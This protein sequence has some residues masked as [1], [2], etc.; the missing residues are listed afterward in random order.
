M[1]NTP[2]A[3][4]AVLILLSMAM[5]SPA[6]GDS[7][8]SAPTLSQ[9]RGKID[10]A[11][12][13]AIYDQQMS[14]STRTDGFGTNLP[15]GLVTDDIVRL[16]LPE[17]NASLATLAGM[18]N[19]PYKEN[20]YIAF[21]CIAPNQLTKERALKY[22]NGKAICNPWQTETKPASKPGEWGSSGDYLM[23]VGMIRKDGDRI[24][25]ASTVVSWS[26]I[27]GSPLAAKWSHSNLFGP[28][29]INQWQDEETE[30][31]KGAL[32][33]PSE[34][35]RFDFARYAISNETVAFG[36]RSGM[37]E[38]YSGG[39]ASFQVL[40]LFA[41]INGELRAIFSEPM[42]YFKD[43][44]GDWNKDGSRKHEIFEGENIVSISDAKTDGYYKLI[45]KSKKKA[46]SKS[47]HW[48]RNLLR[49]VV[50]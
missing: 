47:F 43:M 1:T 20:M 8:K 11:E 5:P 2:A 21:A 31:M 18:K 44:A 9:V 7:L 17:A 42:Y 48:D 27:E 50:D 14:G 41:V 39:G 32:L 45:V 6:R 28:G 4:A 19:W 24:S 36:I 25:L 16:L 3:L 34:L 22:N 13:K 15:A 26:G 29:G 49:Y 12:G 40:T 10:S 33:Y 30:K 38:S 46:W 23:A 37:N 35:Y